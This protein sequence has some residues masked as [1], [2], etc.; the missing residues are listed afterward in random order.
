MNK[1]FFCLVL[2][3]FSITGFSQQI[4]VAIV[5]FD[6]TSGIAKYDGLGKAMSSMLISDIEANVSQKRLQL[7][8]RSQINKILKEQNFQ[9]TSSVDKASTVKM[10]KLLGVKYLLVGDIF[11]LNDAL[12]INSRLVD[13]ETG[14]I[15]FTEKKEGKLTQ[16]LFLKTALAKGLSTSISMPFTEPVISDK[17]INSAVV[18]TFSNA[19][20]EKDKGNLDKAEELLK[21][22]EEFASDFKYI[23]DIKEEIEK[24]KNRVLEL[25]NITNIITNNFELGEKTLIKRDYINSIKY[26]ESFVSNPGKDGNINNKKLFAFSK[27]SFC[28][29]KIGEYKKAIENADKAI[30]IYNYFPEAN[31]VKLI[32]FIKLLRNEDAIKQY[33]FI[34]DSLTYKNELY[35]I[36]N[37]N[38]QTILF[39]EKNY[40]F[41]L[42]ADE[43]SEEWLYAG[44]ENYG[45]Y[46][47]IVNELKIKKTLAENSIKLDMILSIKINNKGFG[48]QYEKLEE[49]LLKLNDKEV[50]SNKKIL[51][52]YY[53]S[54]LYSEE[55]FA[56]KEFKKYEEHLTKEINRIENFGI[57]ST[58]LDE[59]KI[60]QKIIANFDSI[61]LNGYY[62]DEYYNSFYN[63][64]GYVNVKL[65]LI[66]GKFILKQLYYLIE[67][68]NIAAA[69]KLYKK[70]N[71]E[72]VIDRKS[73]FYKNY[74][75][76]I[77]G[78][79]DNGNL[80]ELSD[81]E[82]EIKLDNLILDYLQ[83]RNISNEILQK[84][85]ANKFKIDS[86]ITDIEID[87]LISTDKTIW[88]KN[89]GIVKLKEGLIIHY[90]KNSKEIEKFEK[91]SIPAY[92]Y[93]DHNE[94]YSEKY[95]KLYNYA[96]FKLISENLPL[97]WRIADKFDYFKLLEL[98]SLLVRVNNY[99]K[100]QNEK[101]IDNI[102]QL[103]EI[104]YNEYYEEKIR[105]KIYVKSG[106][107]C[108]GIGFSGIDTQQFYWTNEFT[109]DLKYL[110]IL[111]IYEDNIR[112]S[113]M[114]YND[115]FM[116]IRLIKE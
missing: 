9:K 58:E 109:K 51:N 43:K 7:V 23:D 60:S 90:A 38:K 21:I 67:Q 66:Y 8:E 44:L 92:C 89:L 36:Q 2:I 73:Y 16:W 13:A 69:S 76:L 107:I 53:L 70:L 22:V 12:V 78:F 94:E 84:I 5:D 10:G 24:L 1:I 26:F 108:T 48:N 87:K 47:N 34:I 79:R 59:K 81:K 55:L 77:L 37:K 86:V 57:Q 88:S 113:G 11:I 4:K 111:E 100:T 25:E 15:K 62:D 103:L 98:D 45:Y 106:G 18:T 64:Y 102:E 27:I 19:I 83:K 28:Y 115:L 116:S 99:K 97:G 29:L 85:K 105:Q 75:D 110:K 35:Y 93:Y 101:F 80:K 52:F 33:N 32:A 30:E 74:W 42:K 95:G 6:N 114:L 91:E 54:L 31:E 112:L 49:K 82:F 63:Y 17:E 14:D 65:N 104:G 68:N 46:D 40:N 3:I 96:A 72:Y 56:K 20:S 50:F 41:Q 61:G 39:E 71:T